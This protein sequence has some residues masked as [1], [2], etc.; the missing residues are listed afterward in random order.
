MNPSAAP[1][2]D[3]SDTS[4]SDEETQPEEPL[5]DDQSR[6]S[7]FEAFASEQPLN[8]FGIDTIAAD[9]D[10]QFAPTADEHK[11]TDTSTPWPSTNLDE[12]RREPKL[13]TGADDE[14]WELDESGEDRL[15]PKPT[16]D[17]GQ[18]NV[19]NSFFPE[20]QSPRLAAPRAASTLSSTS[21]SD[22]AEGETREKEVKEQDNY[23]DY[24]AK[25]VPREE[26][27]ATDG[28]LSKSV[29][30]DENIE[31]VAVLTPKDS[32]DASESPSSK[33][34]DD[35]D[36]DADGDTEFNLRTVNTLQ[37]VSDRITDHMNGSDVQEQETTQVQI[38]RNPPR[39]ESQISLTE[40]EDLPPPLPS[41]PPLPNSKS[42]ASFS[43]ALIDRF[44]SRN[45]IKRN[46]SIEIRTRCTLLADRFESSKQS[47]N[48][49]RDQST[50][51]NN[52]TRRQ[53]AQQTRSTTSAILRIRYSDIEPWAFSPVVLVAS[54]EN[55]DDYVEQ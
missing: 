1:E 11:T 51:S 50:Y 55:N 15:A 26:D 25:Q 18:N 27:K 39:P 31:K 21:D 7:H 30:F 33:D 43:D 35:D 45:F 28:P 14:P 54:R 24:F 8:T 6:R 17:A 34:S 22:E 20:I 53:S 40:S 36:D 13:S 48:G 19:Y 46:H 12:P 5:F 4:D 23:D 44:I 49:T 10:N 37:T 2:I 9:I 16:I 42:K 3:D 32:L 47:T 41:L 38:H 52:K 29:R